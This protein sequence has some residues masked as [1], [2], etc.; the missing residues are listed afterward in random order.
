[1]AEVCIA[2]VFSYL[3]ALLSNAIA[4]PSYTL[5]RWGLRFWIAWLELSLSVVEIGLFMSSEYLSYLAGVR[6]CTRF[7]PKESAILIA[8][9]CDGK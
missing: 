2:Y 5:L 7:L 1:M 8:G 6:P 9:T 4:L 3:L